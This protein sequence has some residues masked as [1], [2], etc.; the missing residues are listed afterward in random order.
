MINFNEFQRVEIKVGAILTAEKVKGSEKLVKFSVDFGEEKPRQ[1]V[2]GIAKTFTAPEKLIGKQFLFATNLEPRE[3]MGLQSQAM[4]LA[5]TIQ[6]KSGE[7][8]VLMKPA[9]K[10]PPGSVLK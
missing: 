1:V 2:S 6:K 3:I 9:K 8:I 7:E 10:V 5:A 4:I